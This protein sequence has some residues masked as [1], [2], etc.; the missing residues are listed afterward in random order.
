[1]A[2]KTHMIIIFMQHLFFIF[3]EIITDAEVTWFTLTCVLFGLFL[4]EPE[5]LKK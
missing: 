4:T 2:M 1:M 5:L 3:M